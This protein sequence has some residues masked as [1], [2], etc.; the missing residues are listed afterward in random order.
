M[1]SN[2]QVHYYLNNT[3]NSGRTGETDETELNW[4]LLYNKQIALGLNV[5]LSILDYKT[6]P[7]F[8]MQ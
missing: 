3:N 7:L 8:V 6:E 1:Q 2:I 4:L 5:N